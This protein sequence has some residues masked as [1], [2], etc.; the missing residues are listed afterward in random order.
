MKAVRRPF[1]TSAPDESGQLQAL[2]ALFRENV[3]TEE[4]NT[5][6]FS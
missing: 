5:H 3:F 2:A 1:L 4:H 6:I